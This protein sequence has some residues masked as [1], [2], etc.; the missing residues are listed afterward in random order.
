M[1]GFLHFGVIILHAHR[2]PVE[3]GLP[4]GGDVLLRQSPRIDFDAGLAIGRFAEMLVK[5]RSQFSNF[6]GPKK[7]WR[8][9]AEVHLHDLAMGRFP[10][11]KQRHFLVQIIQ[12]AGAFLMF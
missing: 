4:Q 5:D 2:G 11:A 1:H 9:A 6:I 8:S 12:I 10:V 3:S 7:R